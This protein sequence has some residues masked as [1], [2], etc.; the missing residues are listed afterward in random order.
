MYLSIGTNMTKHPGI[1]STSQLSAYALSSSRTRTI[2]Q[3]ESPSWSLLLKE[4][5]CRIIE[6]L[7]TTSLL[8]HLWRKGLLTPIERDKLDSVHATPQEKAQFLLKIIPRK[9]ENGIKQF[10]ECLMD[11]KDHMGHDELVKCL[12]L[13]SQTRTEV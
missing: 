7:D 9:G 4:H 3:R 5:H 2:Q 11:E 10:L 6:L 13:Y 1:T 8:P 12:G